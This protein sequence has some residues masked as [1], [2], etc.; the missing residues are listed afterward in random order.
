MVTQSAVAEYTESYKGLL[1]QA[2][3]VYDGLIELYTPDAQDGNAYAISCVGHTDVHRKGLLEYLAA[4]ERALS[5]EETS[6]FN[7]STM[8]YLEDHWADYALYPSGNA[9]GIGHPIH[10][11][12]KR[13]RV[14]QLHNEMQSVMNAVAGLGNSLPQRRQ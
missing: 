5:V 14:E 2:V 12:E 7:V 1:R 3:A 10:N 6:T 8:H 4:P 13:Q 11:P 9:A